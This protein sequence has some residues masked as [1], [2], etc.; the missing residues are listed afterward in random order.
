MMNRYFKKI[1][2]LLCI[3][4]LSTTAVW[5]QEQITNEAI[6][7]GDGD[8]PREIQVP[9]GVVVM[10][11]PQPESL[12]G[13]LLKGRAAVSVEIKDAKDPVFGAIWFEAQLNTDR[14][15][16]TANI[17]EVS[18][19]RV[20]FPTE[21][22]QKSERLISLLEKEIPQW[23]FAIS[24]DQLMLTLEREDKRSDMADSISTAPPKIIFTKEPAVLISID[25]E[26]RLKEEPDSDLMRVINTPYTILFE[27]S[28]KHYYLNA[29]ENSWYSTED[30]KGD[31]HPVMTVPDEIASL[32]PEVEPAE[33]IDGQPDGEIEP[34]PIPK[35]I[36][37]TEP[38]ELISASGDPEFTPID[39]TDLLYVS[40]TDS[41]VL[42]SIKDQNYYVLLSGRWYASTNLKGPWKY[43]PGEDLPDD[44]SSI[45][46]ESEMG[47]VLYAVPG[48]E[49]AEEAVLDAQIPQ[50]A[51]VDRN[52]ATL[53]V[54]Y[55]GVPEFETI[56]GVNLSYAVNTETPIIKVE[57]KYYACDDAVWFVSDNAKGSWKVATSVPDVVYTIPPES[58]LYHVTFVR[59]YKVTDD[60]IYIGY[61][62][63]YTGTY[64]YHTTIVY[65]TGYYWPGWYGR[66]YYPRRSTWGFHVRWN[67][68]TGF[69][70][71]LSYSSG[72]FTFSIGRGGWYRGGWWGPSRYR[73]YNRGYRHGHRAG[74]RSGYRAGQR[75]AAQNNLYRSQSN[76]TRMSTQF[77][78]ASNRAKGNT[79]S[80]RANNV[81]TDKDGNIHRKSDK[82]WE[83]RTSDGWKSES[84]DP[85]SKEARSKEAGSKQKPSQTGSGQKPSW[86]SSNQSSGQS[87]EKSSQARQRGA[88][89]SS[90][91]MSS[92][93][94]GAS[95]GGMRGGGGGRR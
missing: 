1:T 48:T 17:T 63:G 81:F 15:E 35:I 60:E 45:P 49:V 55:D 31:W 47:T 43:V 51:A 67:P 32:A 80:K 82:G 18:V 62:P 53:S 87:L 40:N 24:M 38:A 23:Q 6:S 19:T 20:R 84:S 71:G 74:Y 3:Y 58:S 13:N 14:A 75:N 26:P 83:Q 50:T 37:A 41:D 76:K 54:E 16:R 42:K 33:Q 12:N 2:A 36:V 46:E 30:I 94:G 93:G 52:K 86:H 5:A 34:G 4:L 95:G 79:A 57:N 44:F 64:V 78:S 29:D 85:K 59:I 66:Y 69:R 27:P 21:D 89:R 22:E 65:G 7:K 56:E 11:Q 91:T 72:P 10:Y 39:N 73:G 88:Q 68:Y 8:W 25:G 9:E 90:S 77:D 28:T 70:F 92:R 61:T